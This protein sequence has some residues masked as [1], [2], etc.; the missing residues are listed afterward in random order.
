MV[1]GVWGGVRNSRQA[2]NLYSLFTI[3]YSIARS[4]GLLRTPV[5]ARLFTAAYFQYKKHFEDP[6]YGLIRRRPELFRGGDIL[7]VGANIGYCASLFSGAADRGRRVFA[8][9]PEPFNISLLKRVVH[10]RSRGTIVP[11]QAAVGETEGEIR[12]RLN[13]RH[14]GDHRVITTPDSENSGSILVPLVSLDAF[15]ASHDA[16][17]PVCFIK[18]DVQGYE[19]A[20]CRGAVRTLAENCDCSVALEYTP[21]AMAQLGFRAEDL[22]SWFEQRGY[23]AYCLHN[24]GQIT[25]NLPW[26]LGRR[27]YADLLFTRRMLP[28]A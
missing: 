10:A 7:D 15:L 13:P 9:E 27:G 2:V 20:V 12:L 19:L 25:P 28:L 4:T 24:G 1:C 3:P 26:N 23:R 21:D 22:L 6:F 5:G 17:T 16:L 11:V 14:H 8:F 18:I